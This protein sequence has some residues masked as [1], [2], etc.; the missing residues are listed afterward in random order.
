MLKWSHLP[1]WLPA[2]G[3]ADYSVYDANRGLHSVS[4]LK[5]A[6]AENGT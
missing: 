6:L 4:L 5:H 2:N 1:K 3:C